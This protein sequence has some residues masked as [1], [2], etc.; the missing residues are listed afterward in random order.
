MIKGL[1]L[2]R[3][4]LL[5]WSAIDGWAPL[6]EYLGKGVPDEPFPQGNPTTEWAERVGATMKKHNDRALR[7]MAI[8]AAL[9]VA[10]VSWAGYAVLN[11]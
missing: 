7:N 8:F 1:G 6:C 10:L 2:P 5:E 9:L 11:T 4:R 3:E